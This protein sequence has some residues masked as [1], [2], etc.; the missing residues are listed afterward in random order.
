[1]NKKPKSPERAQSINNDMVM[2]FQGLGFNWYF[3]V[4]QRHT[5]LIMPLRG[6]N[7]FIKKRINTSI[8]TICVPCERNF[9]PLRLK[10]LTYQT[11]KARRRESTKARRHEGRKNLLLVTCYLSLVS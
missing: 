2:P 3:T 5:L 10:I 6:K 11:T 1:M 8:S 9:A 4:W 7:I